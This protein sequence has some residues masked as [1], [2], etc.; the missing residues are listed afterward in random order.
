M[1]KIIVTPP[2]TAE[3]KEMIKKAAQETTDLKQL[4][5]DTV[6]VV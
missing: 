3:Q 1:M 5:E 6:I 2:F 4:L